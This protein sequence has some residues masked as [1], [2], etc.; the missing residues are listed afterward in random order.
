MKLVYKKNVSSSYRQ[1]FDKE[2]NDIWGLGISILSMLMNEEYSKYYHWESF[3]INHDTISRKLSNLAQLGY[4]PSLIQTLSGML[5]IE[6]HNRVS[7]K[8]IISKVL[9]NSG[10]EYR[11]IERFDVKESDVDTRRLRE[12]SQNRRRSSSKKR[13]SEREEEH[14]NYNSKRESK[15]QNSRRSTYS[16]NYD[17]NCFSTN[18][19]QRQSYKDFPEYDQQFKPEES[20]RNQNPEPVQQENYNA[21]TAMNY[22]YNTYHVQDSEN[23]GSPAQK[24]REH[25]GEMS[26]VRERDTLRSTNRGFQALLDQTIMTLDSNFG[27]VRQRAQ[28]SLRTQPK[29]RHFE[30][31]PQQPYIRASQR[32]AHN[33]N[34]MR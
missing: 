18:S 11:A 26:P 21:S 27:M 7:I 14:Y 4:T 5:Q 17:S 30:M 3:K 28:G 22:G 9:K 20:Y 8:Y 12:I 16:Q 1:G 15:R 29:E 24:K 33:I 23:F 32:N 25:F 10:T 31:P 19:N 6:E 2:K 13:T 34:F